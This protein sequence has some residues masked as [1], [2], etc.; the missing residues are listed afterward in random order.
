MSSR[1]PVYLDYNATAPTR[2]EVRRRTE[3]LLLEL[4]R[5]ALGNASS[6]H[7]AGRATK[8]AL[9]EARS[10]IAKRLRRKPSQILF[11]GGGTEADNLAILGTLGAAPAS[12]R[13]VTSTVEHPA[14]RQAIASAKSRGA[15][16][17]EVPVSATGALDLTAFDGAL[18]SQRRVLVSIMAVN[19]ETGVRF[20]IDEVVRKAKA[21]NALV[22][23]DAIQAAGRV[24]IELDADLIT[25]SS[26]K[27]GGLSGTGVLA[28]SDRV[29]LTPQVVGGAQERGYRAG[30]EGL[31]GAVAAALALEL[32][33]RDRQAEA[34]RLGALR[35]QLDESI[36]AIP[37]SVILGASESRVAQTTTALFDQIEGDALVQLLDL[38]G[39]AVST[40]SACASGSLEPSHVLLAM[41]IDERRALAAIRISMGYRTVA[42]DVERLIE[43]LPRAVRRCRATPSPL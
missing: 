8:K 29:V 40:G 7:W 19:N 4:E 2:P 18:E 23:I 28:T 37:G 41:G 11:T 25:L 5:G 6:I 10:S 1:P 32:A 38:E 30:T 15:E 22:H 17:V 31:I 34:I 24:P 35:D 26:H 33:E 21:K 3:E 27:L 36:R 43:E 20:P 16:V 9:E 42:E 39:I 13:I 14:V 12:F